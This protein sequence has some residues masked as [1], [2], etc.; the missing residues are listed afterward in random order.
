MTVARRVVERSHE[1][2]VII[3]MIMSNRF[4]KDIIPIYRP[5]YMKNTYGRI[6]CEWV[7]D[8]FQQYEKAPKQHIKDIFEIE[9]ARIEEAD[10]SIIEIFLTKLNR[11]YTEEQE[12]NEDYFID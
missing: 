11:H 3:G 12:I 5:E 10:E 8:Y 9:R 7:L 4:L 1:D 2:K 6:I